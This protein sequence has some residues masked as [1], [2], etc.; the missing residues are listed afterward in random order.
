MCLPRRNSFFREGEIGI[1]HDIIEDEQHV[2]SGLCFL[3][4]VHI[5]HFRDE[6]V[7]PI[8]LIFIEYVLGGDETVLLVESIYVFRGAYRKYLVKVFFML[9]YQP[10][11]QE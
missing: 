6:R 4:F 2:S 9:L 10:F 1:H 5:G 3:T 11:R 8:L 7:N